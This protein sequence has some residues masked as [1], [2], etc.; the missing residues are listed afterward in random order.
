MRAYAFEQLGKPDR[1][2]AAWRVALNQPD[3]AS[4]RGWSY[5]AR[6][7]ALGGHD[8]AAI[9]AT[10]RARATAPNSVVAD[11]VARLATAVRTGCYRPT[12]DSP[13]RGPASVRACD[14]LQVWLGGS[15]LQSAR[16]LQNARGKV[17]AAAPGGPAGSM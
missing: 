2:A 14:P 8:S 4:W 16:E 5:L 6:A 9:A 15:G 10:L 3:N 11:T 12:S 7:L 13:S 17:P 1:A